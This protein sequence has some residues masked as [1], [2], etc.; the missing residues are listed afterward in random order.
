MCV[1]REIMWTAAK[2]SW[3]Q[4]WRRMQTKEKWLHY[5]SILTWIC[6]GDDGG[7]GFVFSAQHFMESTISIVLEAATAAAASASNASDADT[8]LRRKI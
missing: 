7:G 8:L 5:V 3:K 2:L 6:Y 4:K 1:R